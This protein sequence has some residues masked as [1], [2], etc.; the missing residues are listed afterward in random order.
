MVQCLVSD[1]CEVREVQ[2]SV[3]EDEPRFRRFMVQNYFPVCS[4]T[5]WKI[6]IF[7]VILCCKVRFSVQ[8]GFF[9]RF[10]GLKF[11]FRGQT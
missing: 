4:N 9:G 8:F 7:F 5:K 1:Y 11:S 3:L 10:R 2:G 6:Y